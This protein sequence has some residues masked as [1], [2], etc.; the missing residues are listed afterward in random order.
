MCHSPRPA[1]PIAPFSPPL[2][3]DQ[4]G[5]QHTL[6]GNASVLEYFLLIL[7]KHF[8]Q[9]LADQMNLYATQHLPG[10][11]YHWVN[12]SADEMMLFLC[13]HLAM[14]VHEVPSVED[15]RSIHLLLGALGVIQGMPNMPIQGFAKLSA[16]EGQLEGQ[17][18]RSGVIQT[19]QDLPNAGVGSHEL[20]SVL[21]PTQECPSMRLGLY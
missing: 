5:P 11:S 4:A 12:T 1:A 8:F 14:G 3:T 2:F 13:I 16:L 18:K 19:P 10:T 21:Q 17:D 7:G 9:V 20:P 15:Y 6:P